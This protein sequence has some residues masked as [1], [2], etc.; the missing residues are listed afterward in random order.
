[1]SIVVPSRGRILAIVSGGGP[2]APALAGLRSASV[3]DADLE[4]VQVGP[5]A[6]EVNRAATV[7]R[8]DYIV[9]VDA[10]VAVPPGAI[11]AAVEALRADA[12]AGLAGWSPGGSE[13][14][15][16]EL[17]TPLT[18]C[19]ARHRAFHAVEGLPLDVVGPMAAVDLGWRIWLAGYRVRSTG[20]RP[21]STTPPIERSGTDLA[22]DTL[23]L[24]ATVLDDTSIEPSLWADAPAARARSA[25]ITR[26]F[27]VQVGRRRGDGE[28][29]PLAHRSI[30]AWAAVDP[31]AAAVHGVMARWGAPERSGA[32]RKVAVV[33]ADTLAGRMAGPG[34][35]ALQIARRL[36]AEHDVVLATTGRCELAGEPFEVRSVAEKGLRELERWCDVFLFQGWIL[37][38]REA[39]LESDKV[40]IADVYDPMHL[41]QLEQA[42][43]AEGERGRFDA[44]RNA[45]HVLNEQLGRAD[46]MLCASSKQRDLWLGQLAALG[47][48]NPVTYDGD[49][50]LASLLAVVPFGVGDAPPEQTR[51]AIRAEVPGIGP[52]D[53]VVLWGGGVYNWFDP[54][55]LIRAVD[56]LRARVPD[57]RLYFLG[58]RHPNPDIPEMRMAVATQELARELG[59]TGTHV[60]FNEDWVPFE[61]R[62]NYLLDADV[63]VSTHLDHIETEFSFRTRILD[64]LWAG[65]PILATEGDSF[66]QL[67]HD[68]G[69]GVVVPACDVA[70][71]E[72]G[73]E[74]LLTDPDLGT[75]CR[76]HIAAL[77]PDLRWEVCLD[78]LVDFCRRARRAADVACIDLDPHA[79]AAPVRRGRRRDLEVAWAYLRAGGP[80]LVWDRAMARVR[81]GRR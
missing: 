8:N 1:M 20:P 27:R 36:H 10:G 34:I 43:D 58:L 25:A 33:T 74:R 29:L 41:E 63:G 71:V 47:R 48:I 50:S 54:L 14:G 81:R 23:T 79:G 24:L 70:A 17:F 61:D 62:Q 37:A 4:V 16:L 39:L 42:R 68:E 32:R 31:P 80:R 59:L 66:A 9:L 26:R 28:M 75:A 30:A 45:G 5:G 77:T 64:Y 60:F 13:A 3:P 46:F 44:V 19:V 2:T 35:R 53:K 11:E 51:S 6:D 76:E 18:L 21:A 55:T 56:R 69:L 40:V 52:A 72:A 65:L 49:E 15:T 22:S 12:S 57:I 7:E 78:P 67:I 73:L 38:G